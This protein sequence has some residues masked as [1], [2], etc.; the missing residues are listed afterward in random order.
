MCA[1]RFRRRVSSLSSAQYIDE[2]KSVFNKYI[3]TSALFQVNISDKQRLAI[4]SELERAWK[5]EIPSNPRIFDRA[6]SEVF[7]LM[8][9]GA[10]PR[11]RTSQLHELLKTEIIASGGQVIE[12]SAHGQ[13][14]TATATAATA[15][16]AATTTAPTATAAAA[17]I[18]HD[19]KFEAKASGPASVFAAAAAVAAAASGSAALKWWSGPGFDAEPL[20]RFTRRY[21]RPGPLLALAPGQH[22]QDFEE[23]LHSERGL[24]YFARCVSAEY[25]TENLLF[26]ACVQRFKQTV[27][28]TAP[29]A[30]TAMTNS[31]YIDETRRIHK[32]YIRSGSLYSVNLSDRSR[33]ALTAELEKVWSGALTT[34]LNARVFDATQTEVFNTMLNGPYARFRSGHLN[35]QLKNERANAGPEA[36]AL[37]PAAAAASAASATASAA[38]A[39]ATAT[40][41]TASG[42]AAAAFAAAHH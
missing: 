6:Q 34:P 36:T 13:G 28:A 16:A 17:A 40:S 32:T 29:T 27:T 21:P 9:T 26:W 4:T 42:G 1:Q 31:Q 3:S 38:S 15:T 12:P 2:T 25:A 19:T 33:S 14:I 7:Q 5:S 30:P 20:P 10:F 22:A 8:Y 24:L 18:K 11:F 35:E 23:L 41:P 37:I 39:T